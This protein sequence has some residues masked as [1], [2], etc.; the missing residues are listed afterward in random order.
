MTLAHGTDR[1]ESSRLVLRRI[2][3]SDLPFFARI[4]ALPGGRAVSLARGPTALAGTV[5]RM[6]AVHTREL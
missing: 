5:G 2:T 6:A 1:L 3:P 4:H